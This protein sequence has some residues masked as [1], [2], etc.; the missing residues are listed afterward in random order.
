MLFLGVLS[1]GLISLVVARHFMESVNCCGLKVD[2]RAEE[3]SSLFSEKFSY[4]KYS[5]F[6][7]HP[8]ILLCFLLG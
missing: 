2:K 8:L 6:E 3:N 5:A 7:Y 1:V 4:N